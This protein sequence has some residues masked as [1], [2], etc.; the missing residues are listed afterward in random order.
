MPGGET[1][2]GSLLRVKPYHDI[3]RSGKVEGIAGLFA[4]N[5]FAN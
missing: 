2:T 4:S 3:L 1:F 5:G